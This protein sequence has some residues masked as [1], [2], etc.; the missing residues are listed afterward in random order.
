MVR[1]KNATCVKKPPFVR[2]WQLLLP[3]LLILVVE[4]QIV[5]T[6]K[7]LL[8]VKI[9]WIGGKIK[10]P[11]QLLVVIGVRWEKRYALKPTMVF[12]PQDG[13]MK[14]QVELN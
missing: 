14:P 10:P 2:R 6:S 4:P 8:I 9:V 3:L 7:L 13:S 12:Y 1:W 5:K 11:F